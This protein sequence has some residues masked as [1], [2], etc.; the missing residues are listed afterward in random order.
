MIKNSLRALGLSTMAALL[1]GIIF[2]Y[3]FYISSK[4][5]IVGIPLAF[6]VFAIPNLCF[7]LILYYARIFR[8]TLVDSRFLLVEIALVLIVDRL[9]GFI[10]REYPF[11]FRFLSTASNDGQH[12]YPRPE[13]E[14]LSSFIIVFCLLLIMKATLVIKNKRP[15]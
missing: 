1:D 13:L 14:L 4:F 2:N 12:F 15:D 10:V 7:L 3:D 11:A 5:L 9:L 6:L 8:S